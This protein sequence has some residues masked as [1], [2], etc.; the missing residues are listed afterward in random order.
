MRNLSSRSQTYHGHTVAGSGVHKIDIS[1]E[2]R[3]NNIIASQRSLR[4]TSRLAASSK[5][6]PG[7]IRPASDETNHPGDFFGGHY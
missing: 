4:L 3:V 1:P 7:S 6:S 2:A 5:D